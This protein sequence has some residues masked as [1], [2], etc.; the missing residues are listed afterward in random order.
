MLDSSY[1]GGKRLFVLAYDNTAGNNQVSVD[2]HQKY[3]LPRA[4]IENW[5]RR[6]WRKKFLWSAN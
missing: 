6:K 3:L 2:S 4:K 5:K 1:E